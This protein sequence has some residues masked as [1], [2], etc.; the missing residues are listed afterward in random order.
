MCELA[1]LLLLL[2]KNN[3]FLFFIVWTVL[4]GLGSDRGK[5]PLCCCVT[6]EFQRHDT[7]VKTCFRRSNVNI[8]TQGKI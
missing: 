6:V 7:E 1:L 2:L 5:S 8:Y 3:I 4:L